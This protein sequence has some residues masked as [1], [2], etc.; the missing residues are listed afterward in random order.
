MP[1]FFDA[2]MLTAC[3]IIGAVGGHKLRLPAPTF[4]GPLILAA[5]T[6]LA[7]ITE[8]LPP[9]DLVNAAQVVLGTILGCRFFG[10][11]PG[12]VLRA[13]L[14][15]LGATLITLALAFV[16]S[17]AMRHWAGVSLDQAMLALASGGLTGMGLIG[18]AI[19]ADVAFVA[20]HHVWRILVA[21]VVAPPLLRGFLAK[22]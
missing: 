8:G 7:G 4:L 13:G 9:P 17:L 20:L 2:A 21:I 3:A 1:G 16:A 14:L 6:H 5:A 15:S 22:R 12:T 10:I 19:Q 11:A 18:L